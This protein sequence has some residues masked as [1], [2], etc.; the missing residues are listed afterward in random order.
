MQKNLRRE[1]RS[2]IIIGENDHGRLSLLAEKIAN[3]NETLSETLIG[4][5]DRAK[6]VPEQ[7]VPATVIRMGSTVVWRTEK[8][9]EHRAKLVFPGDADINSGKVSILT[10]V[11]VAL[12]GLSTG[13]A[14]EWMTRD[15]RSHALTVLKVEN[16]LDTTGTSPSRASN[17]A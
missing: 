13:Q 8:G 10:P 6:V 9:E 4:E 2:P 3:L 1:R 7:R 16:T 17:D 11:G 14:M 15:G 12:I 5:L